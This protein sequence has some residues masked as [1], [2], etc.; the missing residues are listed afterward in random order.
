M[1]YLQE[2]Y[3]NPFTDFGFKKLFGEE[4]N[5]D[6]LV[7]FLNTLLEGQEHIAELTYKKNDQLGALDTDRKAIFDVYCENERGEKFIIE[8]QKA[9]QNYFKERSI[10]Y[11]TF[12]IQEQAKRGP[13]DFQMK[14]VYTVGILDFVFDDA[15]KDKTVVA[16]VMLMDKRR[17]T[18]F[19]D[20]LTYV[21]LQMPN[22]T[23][24][25]AELE[26]HFDKWLF[27]LKN[28]PDL[29]DRPARLQERIFQ[30]LFGV[31]ELAKLSRD[32]RGAYEESLKVF[33]DLKNTLDTARAEGLEEGRVEGRAE[34]REEGRA[35][36]REE[37]GQARAEQMALL[38][39]AG[40]ES[41]EKIMLYTGLTMA[42]VQRLRNP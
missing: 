24:T 37:G 26:T 28:L 14:A 30:K 13:W 35:E 42:Q 31:A 27:V 2:R 40:G 36:G 4:P 8:L 17:H 18:V 21:Y 9:K 19:Y 20:K 32:D 10:F 38:M 41:D 16:E 3:I 33:R 29:A 12:P 39:M 23:K 15:D 34:G 11:S 7:D 6:L 5:K 25:E 22:F 1:E